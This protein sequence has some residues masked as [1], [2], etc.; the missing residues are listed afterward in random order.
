[1]K[2]QNKVADFLKRAAMSLLIPVGIW[3]VFVVAVAIKNGGF[4]GALIYK[5]LITTLRQMVQPA[6]IC[7]GLMLNM[8][9]GMMNF[10]AGGMMLFAGIIGGTLAKMTGTGVVGL[11]AF[12]VLVCIAEGAVNGL[13]YNAMRV[14]CIVLTIGMM[15]VWESF[16]KLLVPDGL[17]L[18]RNPGMTFLTRQPYCFIVLAIMAVI[19]YVIYNK[20]AFGHNMRALGNNQAIANSVGLDSDK[21]KFLS[22]LLGSVFL[23]M[24][25]VMYVSNMGEVRNVSTMGSMTIMMDGFMGMFIALFIAKYCDMTLAI[26]FGV[27]TMKMMTNGFVALGVSATVRDIV[28]GFFLLIL[29]VI[30][31]NSGLFERRKLDEEYRKA[32]NDAYAAKIAN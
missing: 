9:L 4:N 15:L 22:F 28:Q 12:C 10:S 1:M 2:Q 8:L 21:I 3:A 24:G 29:L 14:P 20:T 11:V 13:L 31:A 30:Q 6:L 18:S 32:C 16:P 27:F 19:F 26:P 7:Y 5:Q 17:N 23:G 25:S